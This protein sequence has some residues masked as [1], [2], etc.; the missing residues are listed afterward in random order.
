M[1]EDLKN[2]DKDDREKDDFNSA[3]VQPFLVGKSQK[4][5]V[6]VLAVFA[7]LVLGI[8]VAQ[9][10]KNLNQPFNGS[11]DNYALNNETDTCSDGSCSDSVSEA[12][13]RAKD[14]DKDGLNDW[15]ELNVYNTSPYLEDSDS[16]GFSDKEEIN[17]EEDPN[18]P[19]GRDCYSSGLLNE[20]IEETDNNL[21]ESSL[22][23]L[24]N[25]MGY[26]EN[27]DAVNSS[28]TD[29]AGPLLSDNIDASTLRELLLSQGMD[30][31]IL[32]QISDELLMTSF[33]EIAGGN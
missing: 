13:L 12:E 30:K 18:C 32:D 11:S 25:Q 27:Q 2:Y 33:Q 15:D 10:K 29:G 28:V 21:E 22:N 31:E 23:N 20:N 14:T 3:P 1:Q 7:F 6:A 5:A 4:I 24:L 9:F 16:D 26:G 17:N 8:W 19:S